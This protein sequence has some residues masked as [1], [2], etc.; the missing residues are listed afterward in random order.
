[1]KEPEARDFHPPEAAPVTQRPRR[2]GRVLLIGLAI[3]VALLC[4]LIYNG[5][6]ERSA[7]EAA[8]ETE[9]TQ[10]AAPFVEVVHP[11]GDAP[12][13]T[14]VLPG[15]TMAFVDTPIYARASGYLK[16]WNYDIGAHVKRGDVL[17][18]IETPELDQQLREAQAQLAQNEAA[19]AQAQA[20]MDLAKVTSGRTSELVRQ[21]W[22]SRQQGDQD[23]LTYAA[24]T[25]AV[26]VARAN[27]R[28]AQAQVDRLEELT[29]FERVTAPFDGVIT[30]RNTDVGALINAGAGGP[31]TELFHMASTGT[32]RIFVAVPEID[33][34]DL[35][36]GN[37]ASVT[38]DEYPGQVF[39]G[40]LARTDGMINPTSRTLLVEVDVANS[41]GKLLPGAYAFVRF[42]L[43]RR[44]H[45]VVIPA[46]ALLFR[47]E[48]LRVALV[49][50]SVAELV[51]ITIGRDYGDRVEVLTGL[52]T[53]DEV[54]LNPS[55][56]LVSGAAVR[57]ANPPLKTPDARLCASNAIACASPG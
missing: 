55:D 36:A 1:M 13:Q 28:V 56:S 16:S 46:N 22:N 57:L 48:G 4:G 35:R 31:A 39:H 10:A 23:R 43:K 19:V 40:T 20:N 15:Q 9:T 50:N 47:S 18:Q 38:F 45:S 24:S 8:L 5:M 49:R 53:T 7:A 14:L 3:A 17:A 11:V 34:P 30:A 32:L 42:T 37:I 26:N 33:A 51:P 21:G 12:D 27:V 25:A 44:N 29:A 52:N 2:R 54:I 6:R 41:D